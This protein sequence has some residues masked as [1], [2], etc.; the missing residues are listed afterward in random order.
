VLRADAIKGGGGSTI[1]LQV[2]ALEDSL[3]QR[4]SCFGCTP[5]SAMR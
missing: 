4:K 3:R 1:T 5:G 2:S